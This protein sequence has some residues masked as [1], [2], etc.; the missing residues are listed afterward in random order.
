MYNPDGKLHPITFHSWTF[1]G[2]DLNSDVHDKEL[3]AIY[4]AFWCWRHYLE[5]PAS[6]SMLSPI[7]RIWSISLWW[8]QAQWSKYLSQ[9]N[10]TIWFWP[11]NLGMKLD[12]LTRWWD[13]YLKEGGSNYGTI[14]PQNLR[15]IFT[16][17]Q[18]SKSLRTMSLLI[19]VLCASVLM[20]S[21]KLYA[22]ILAHLS[23]DPVAQKHIGIT[24]DP[25]WM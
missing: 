22:G 2:T 23:S 8:R 13:V 19:P 15:L 3:L 25:R 11:R 10:M 20:D 17:Q 1:S 21:K 5:G 9:F 18:L 14:N 7:T 4:K 16:T 12:T 6:Q 24:S